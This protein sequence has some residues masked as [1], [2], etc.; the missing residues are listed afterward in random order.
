MRH[1][2]ARL[3]GCVAGT[4]AV[5]APVAPAVAILDFVPYATV[6]TEYDSNV[7]RL[8]DDVADALDQQQGDTLQTYRGG[9]AATYTAGLQTFT[10]NGSVFKV[11]YNDLSAFDFNGYDAAGAWNWQ[12]GSLVK[13]DLSAG[14][15]R[16]VQSFANRV[17]V[18]ERSLLD[19]D[20]AS[21]G[22]AIKVLAEF[23]LRPRVTT[24]RQRYTGELSRTQDLDTDSASLGLVY[25][26]L[27][28]FTVGVEGQVSRGDFVGRE[29]APGVVEESDQ[30]TLSL[31]GTWAPSVITNVAFSLG[32]TKRDNKGTDVRDEPAEF[33]G[34]LN[35]SRNV[36]SKTSAYAGVYRSVSN[37]INVGESTVI[38][39][40]FN[41]GLLWGIS[42]TLSAKASYLHQRDDFQDSAAAGGGDRRDNLDA[43]R[44][45]LSYKPREWLTLTPSAAWE[46]RSS[47][48]DFAAY[49][50][51]QL[52]LDV[53]ISL[54][55]R[56]NRA[57]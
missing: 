51:Y 8:N 21:F 54:P 5:L 46:D 56:L 16:T 32:S 44:A 38:S 50:A 7:Q 24:I 37:A 55:S 14:T 4:A 25:L 33:V 28:K 10:L 17:V 53:K 30:T 11:D 29:A 9:F 1:P 6:R 43:L 35:M 48:V 26:G 52:A 31:I 15:S 13:G 39:T 40:G 3:L 42:R 45:E 12:V 57:P 41:T 22:A 18:D 49:D 36:S 20:T 47:N 27:G 2:R 19:T 34:S 23:E